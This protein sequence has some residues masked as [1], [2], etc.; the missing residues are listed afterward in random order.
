VPFRLTKNIV[1]ALGP[2]GLDGSFRATCVD[3][4]TALRSAK[5]RRL[6]TAMAETLERDVLIEWELFGAGTAEETASRVVNTIRRKLNGLEGGRLEAMSPGEQVGIIA[7]ATTS[8]GRLPRRRGDA[9]E[10]F[11]ADVRGLVRL[12]VERR[13]DLR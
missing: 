8:P 12:G 11:G 2:T 13:V 1:A 3:V 4:L 7:K 5:G 6:I 10:Q 9:P